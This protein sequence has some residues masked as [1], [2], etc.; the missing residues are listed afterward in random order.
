MLI[1]AKLDEVQTLRDELFIAMMN[2]GL[3]GMTEEEM[4]KFLAASREANGP[5]ASPS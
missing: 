5:G 3:I 1:D 2:D 4:K